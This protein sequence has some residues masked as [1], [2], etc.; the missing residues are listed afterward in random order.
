MRVDTRSLTLKKEPATEVGSPTWP[1]YEATRRTPGRKALL[2]GGLGAGK[3]TLLCEF[4]ERTLSENPSAVAF[5]VPATALRVVEH[6]TV[7][8]IISDFTRY[9][10]EQI[11]TSAIRLDIV[12]LLTK[13]VELTAVIDGLD[14]MNIAQ[15]SKLL[16]QLVIA[17]EHWPTLQ[18]V[19]A[20]RP[21]ELRGINYSVWTVLTTL[22]INQ[23]ER[24]AMF[25]NELEAAGVTDNLEEQVDLLDKE[26]ARHTSVVEL[27]SSP[28]AIRLF[29]PRL[30]NGIISADLTLGDLLIDAMEE[31][32]G[33]WAE[34]DSKRSVTPQLDFLLPTAR[35]RAQLLGEVLSSC[36]DIRS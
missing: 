3:S 8:E 33:N 21:I 20:S 36:Q 2:L 11:G 26:I 15:A 24:R 5:I 13:G 16:S 25:R 30:R 6:P 22:S 23:G 31:R 34:R 32:L 9:F 27:L 35:S 19:A 10:D 7:K 4:V 17:T 12:S 29:F 14:E 28:L 18:I 1:L